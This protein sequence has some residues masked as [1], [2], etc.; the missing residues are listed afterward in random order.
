MAQSITRIVVVG[1]SNTDMVIKTPRLPGPG[2]TVTG[3]TFF[4]ARGG[5][6]ANQ[7]VAAARAG[8]HVTFIASIGRDDL[9]DDAVAAFEQDGIDTTRV[10]RTADAASGVALIV[11]D[12]AGENAIAVAEG[13]NSLLSPSEIRKC[14]AVIASARVLVAQLEIPLETVSE[15]ARIAHEHGVSVILNPAPARLLPDEL[16][17]RVSVLTPNASEAAL[18]AGQDRES[19]VDRAATALLAR[20]A[21]AVVVTLGADGVLVAHAG[22]RER[23]PGWQVAAEDTTGAGDVFNGALAAALADGRSL[24]DAARFANAAAAISVTRR[25]AQ[26][27]APRRH[28]IIDLL[29]RGLRE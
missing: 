5:K 8:G 17:S 13:A 6:G 14:A 16:L 25:G 9:G 24:G 11:V 26:P 23:I 4:R 12:A 27:S 1:S 2:E 28:E 29:E 7:A 21:G 18:L 3:G 19:S 10:G 15:A 22:G 20:G